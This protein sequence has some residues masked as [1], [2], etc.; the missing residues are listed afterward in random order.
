VTLENDSEVLT[1]GVTDSTGAYTLTTT[2]TQDSVRTTPSCT[3]VDANVR[4]AINVIDA[5][6]A[7]RHI[8]GL[9][10][11]TRLQQ[12]AADVDSGGV[13][14][15][16]VL[17]ML[18]YT[19]DVQGLPFPVGD[20]W[21]F[22]PAY[23]GYG[24]LTDDLVDQDYRAMIIGDANG[25]YGSG[26]APKGLTGDDGPAMAWVRLGETR[27]AGA[28]IAIPVELETTHPVYG[29]RIELSYPEEMIE[30]VE[31][32][33]PKG[34]R[35]GWTGDGSGSVRMALVSG[36]P[37]A[38]DG[39]ILAEMVFAPKEDL[40]ADGMDVH[41]VS[42]ELYDL[43]GRVPV[44]IGPPEDD[45]LPVATSLH[46]NCPNPFN[47]RTT[48]R[49]DVAKSGRVR[50]TLYGLTGQ[51]IRTLVDGERYAGRYSVVWDGRDDAGRDVASGVYLCRMEGGDYIAVRKL[52]L[53]R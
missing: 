41:I 32:R 43:G 2:S 28:H 35:K 16:D 37:L 15:S 24:S 7:L 53:V 22:D 25:D 23:R 48:I 51:R 21:A 3:R 39:T 14:I 19:L 4:A 42:A 47:P 45:L 13:T 26:I 38:S 12:V 52:V 46:Q 18:D 20:I 30:V 33:V 29:G 5:I 1:T 17:C 11:L 50:L 36:M 8:L 49:Y 10:T 40:P 6:F 31:I 9:D 27:H 44:A 34:M